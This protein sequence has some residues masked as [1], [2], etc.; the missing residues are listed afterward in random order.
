[1]LGPQSVSALVAAELPA[2]N[3]FQNCPAVIGVTAD[4]RGSGVRQRPPQLEVN[5]G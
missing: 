2:G 4:H 1:M 5:H 3:F